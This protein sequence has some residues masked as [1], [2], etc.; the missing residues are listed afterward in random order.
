MKFPLDIIFIRDKKIV[1]MV[2]NL[3]APKSATEN[4]QIYNPKAPADAV[5]E[6][7]AGLSS[8]YGFKEGDSVTIK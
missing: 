3:Q 8:K 2:Q 6:I 1:D 5:L 4:P 7:N